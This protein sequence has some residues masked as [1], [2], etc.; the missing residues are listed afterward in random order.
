MSNY[1]LKGFVS[2]DAL[3][4]NMPNVTAPLGEIS[5]YALTYAT[6]RG[7]YTPVARKELRV[8]AFK[9]NSQTQGDI[10]IPEEIRTVMFDVLLWLYDQRIATTTP[11]SADVLRV[12][13][14]DTFDESIESVSVGTVIQNTGV[15]EHWFPESIVFSVKGFT[16]TNTVTL[17]LSDQRFRQQYSDYEMV[18]V[19]AL[20]ALDT[21]FTTNTQ[22]ALDVAAQNIQVLSSRIEVARNNKPETIRLFPTYPFVGLEQPT[23]IP[24]TWPVLIYGQAGNS[25][26][27]IKQRLRE[28][29]LANSTHSLA[30]WQRIIPDLFLST[31]FQIFPT[32]TQ[33]ALGFQQLSA[34]VYRSSVNPNQSA[35]QVKAINPGMTTAFINQHMEMMA[36]SYRGIQL[37]VIGSGDNPNEAFKLSGLYP[38]IA[39]VSTTSADFDRLSIKTQNFLRA[40]YGALRIAEDTA[41]LSGALTQY[42]LV[43]RDGKQYVSFS[44]DGA[45]YVVL[46][47]ASALSA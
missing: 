7:I 5:A 12:Q 33:I 9:S 35:L 23:S 44:A 27:L 40:L 16:L 2:I 42:G 47:K 45:D 20:P 3:A 1:T 41:L 30:D 46:T 43:T 37:A 36:T 4:T 38:D 28:F 21:F 24:T 29:I 15:T 6:D 25:I 39:S 14:L 32:W 18:C 34:G 13:M 11:V 19:G 10:L 26:D 8:H 22:V 17:W 31:E